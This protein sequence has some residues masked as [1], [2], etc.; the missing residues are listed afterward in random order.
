M[1]NINNKDHEELFKILESNKSSDSLEDDF[2]SSSISYYQSANVSSD[3]KIGCR[4]S[5]CNNIKTVKTL[6]KS[7]EDRKHKSIVSF[8][9]TLKRLNQKKS[10]DLT[11]N[12]LQHEI[13]IVK[14]EISEL[15]HKNKNN[16]NHIKPKLIMLKV[17]KSDNKHEHKDGD[18]SNQQ[19]L[20]S[21]KGIANVF[22]D[23]QLAL[24]KK[25]LPPKLFTK[26]RI[27]VSPDYHFTVIAMIVSGA[28]MNCI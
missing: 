18:E 7:E 6:T 25:I 9:E 22:T 13:N 28:D 3:I 1:L 16:N 8:E 11:I 4:N 2:S 10:K 19:A 17:D 12:D 23:S 24:V 27:V 5:C 26:V 14:Q 15:K 20:L 21:D